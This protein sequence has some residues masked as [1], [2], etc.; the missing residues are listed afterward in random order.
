MN[1]PIDIPQSYI[2]LYGK[3]APRLV[4][5]SSTSSGL[6]GVGDAILIDLTYTQPV[7]VYGAPTLTLN[8]GCNDQS[9][10]IKEIQSFV[11]YADVGMFGIKIGNQSLPNIP[12][13]ISAAELTKRFK[14]IDGINSITIAYR[15]IGDSIYSQG[16]RACAS[17]GNNVTIIFDDVSFPQYQ[18]NI[19]PIFFDTN[20]LLPGPR[21]L[22][23]SG[24][25]SSRL[26][27]KHVTYS[28]SIL[29]NT[30]QDGFNKTDSNATYIYGNG[31][32]V[33]TF[34]YIVEYG[35][36]TSNLD[37]K[38]INYDF[39]YIYDN[40]T[41][42]AISLTVP[43]FG[44]GPR[45]ITKQASSLSFNSKL[46][47][48]SKV[49]QVSYVTSPND[50]GLY[51]EG[52]AIYIYV[53]FD[54]PIKAVNGDDLSL[55]LSTGTFKRFARYMNQLN[56]DSLSFLHIVQTGDTAAK[57][58][59]VASSSLS[60]G[61]AGAIYR[62]S[63]GNISANIT[64]PNPT[65]IGSLSYS[66]SIQVNTA[67]PYVIKSEVSSS[68]SYTAGDIIEFKLSFSYPVIVYGQ[69][70]F[71][72]RN[73]PR[74]L[75]ARIR[76][77]PANPSF[78][79][80]SAKPDSNA[81]IIV[82]LNTNFQLAMGD[83][84]RIYLPTGF[85]I[86]GVDDIK[87]ISDIR[88]LTISGNDSN[89]FSSI[90][91]NDTIVVTRTSSNI[92]QM[93]DSISITISPSS[94]IFTSPNGLISSAASLYYE[95]ISSQ[96]PTKLTVNQI[97]DVVSAIGIRN[98][99]LMISAIHNSTAMILFAFD[100]PETLSIG[101]TISLAFYNFSSETSTASSIY[102]TNSL[103]VFK[104]TWNYSGND[105]YSL[106]IFTVELAEN[107]INQLFQINISD[108][109][110]LQIP[111]G[112][113]TSDSVKLSSIMSQ[114]GVLDAISIPFISKIC[115]IE[116]L[117]LQYL[118]PRPG[119]VSALTV[120][121]DIP[122]YL[123]K[124]DN[125]TIYLPG[126]QSLSQSSI[127]SECSGGDCEYFS[128]S[129][130]DNILQLSVI[131]S[132]VIPSQISVTL[133]S[134]AGI[135]VPYD[136]IFPGDTVI[137]G[138]IAANSCSMYY[139]QYIRQS[140]NGIISLN[141]PSISFI[142][143][144]SRESILGQPVS[145]ILSFSTRFSLYTR[146]TISITLPG[147]YLSST[148][149]SYLDIPSNKSTFNG[150]FFFNEHS[151]SLT[152][153][154][155]EDIANKSTF[156]NDIAIQIPFSVGLICS[157]Q[158]IS[159]NSIRIS[160]KSAT[161]S[162]NN[163]VVAS[164]CYGFCYSDINYST[165]YT[166]E[167]L[168]VQITVSFFKVM[169]TGSTIRL[170]AQSLDRYHYSNIS[171][172]I[173]YPSQERT[174]NVTIIGWNSFSINHILD[175]P[176]PL[177]INATR[178]FTMSIRGL[179]YCNSSINSDKIRL[180]Y[181]SE[182]E[183]LVTWIELELPSYIYNRL[184]FETSEMVLPSNS[185]VDNSSCIS[186]YFVSASYIPKDY[187]LILSLPN[188]NQY[189]N[190]ST[191]SPAFNESMISWDGEEHLLT[192]SFLFGIIPQDEIQMTVC[193]LR[194]DSL[195]GL[196]RDSN[197]L[198]YSIS[199]NSSHIAA[200]SPFSYVNPVYAITG[201]LIDISVDSDSFNLSSL[202]VSFHINYPLVVGD[203]IQLQISF[204]SIGSNVSLSSSFSSMGS[205]NKTQFILSISAE[206]NAASGWQY[207]NIF[208]TLMT[209]SEGLTGS[210][211]STISWTRSSDYLASATVSVPCVGICLIKI[212]PNLKKSGYIM[213]YDLSIRFDSIYPQVGDEI[214]IPLRYFT[215]NSSISTISSNNVTI[216][217]EGLSSEA[218]TRL[219]FVYID[220]QSLS[221]ISF[222]IPSS[223]GLK[224]PSNGIR[225]SSLL[226]NVSWTSIQRS[227]SLSYAAL[228]IQS[229]GK[230]HYLHLN[231]S[232]T[233]PGV[234]ANVTVIMSLLD[235][236]HEG[237]IFELY[238]PGFV[239]SQTTT[240]FDRTRATMTV[241]P[242]YREELANVDGS[243]YFIDHI[244]RTQFLILENI[245]ADSLIKFDVCNDVITPL[246][247]VYGSS[248]PRIAL[249]SSYS[250]IN[251]ITIA[252]TTNIGSLYPISLSYSVS[253]ESS[254]QS[255]YLNA[256]KVSAVNISFMINC[257]LILNDSIIFPLPDLNMNDGLIKDYSIL[258]SRNTSSFT[259]LWIKS[260]TS[261]TMR[262]VSSSV[263]L[264][265]GNIQL[266]IYPSNT[267]LRPKIRYLNAT[268]YQYLIQSSLCPVSDAI[269]D[270]SSTSLIPYSSVS[271]SCDA[272]N[273]S[274]SIT[275]TFSCA[276][277]LTKND[278]IVINLPQ[279]QLNQ[280]SSIIS[281]LSDPF[282][283]GVITSLSTGLQISL[284]LASSVSAL[285]QISVTIPEEF[286][287]TS[288]MYG[289]SYEDVFLLSI[290]SN[291]SLLLS[292]EVN[293]PKNIGYFLSSSIDISSGTAG[294]TGDITF[295]FRLSCSLSLGDKVV[296]YLP[297]FST[298]DGA[299][300]I[301]K[302]TVNIIASWD[303]A[304]SE[305]SFTMAES[306]SKDS[307]IS[308]QISSALIFPSD[309]ISSDSTIFK[310]STVSSKCPVTTSN[311]N[312]VSILPKM[313][314][315][316]S[317]IS[318]DYPDVYR[319]GGNKRLIVLQPGHELTNMDIG[320]LISIQ[321]HIYT[322]ENIE[323]NLLYIAEN[324]MG[325]DIFLGQPYTLIR[326]SP[327]RPAVY[328]SGSGTNELYFN[329][330]VRRGD[331]THQLRLQ[332]VSTD[333]YTANMIDL[334]DGKIYRKSQSPSLAA[335]LAINELIDE[336][337]SDINTDIPYI[338]RIYSTSGDYFYSEGDCIDI[339]VEFSHPVI[340]KYHSNG[341]EPYL[342]LA[343]N[344]QGI[345]KA[346]YSSGLLTN[347]LVFV[348]T[349][350]DIDNQIGISSNFI[351]SVTMM[352]SS[353]F[354]PFRVIMNNK[355][356][357]LRRLSNYPTLDA[358]VQISRNISESFNFNGSIDGQAP[359]VSRIYLP[360]RHKTYTSGDWLVIYVE[361]TS[362][363]SINTDLGSPYIMIE[364]GQTDPQTAKYI[365]QIDNQ[366]I[367]FGYRFSIDDSID[368]GLYLH[369]TCQDYF[370]RTMI[371]LN[372]SIIYSS[373]NSAIQASIILAKDSNDSSLAI[374][375]AF[376]L[377]NSSP[378]IFS[379]STNISNY[380]V[381]DVHSVGSIIDISVTFSYSIR[382]QGLVWMNLK[383]S[384]GPCFAF[385]WYGNNT[386]VLHFLYRATIDS[387]VAKLDYLTTD[388]IFIHSG[389]IRRLSDYPIVDAN[390]TLFPLGNVLSLG[391]S[392]G[393]NIN[394][395][396][397]SIIS[398]EILS[399][400][401]PYPIV[402]TLSELS[403]VYNMTN[404]SIVLAT[405]DYPL[406][407]Y[408]I[409]DTIISSIEN[410]FIDDISVVIQ[411]SYG[412]DSRSILHIQQSY[413][414]PFQSIPMMEIE[415]TL[416]SYMTPIQS[417]WWTRYD[418]RSS[419]DFVINFDRN[420]TG[421]G[422]YL[423]TSMES[424]LNRA[425][426]TDLARLEY[427]LVA[428]IQSSVYSD[429]KYHQFQFSYGGMLSNCLTVTASST[430]LDSIAAGINSIPSLKILSP[431]VS[432]M[433]STSRYHI[434]NIQFK[435]PLSYDLSVYDG[436]GTC[437][438]PI[439]PNQVIFLSDES[440][441]FR[442]HIRSTDSIIL[443]V[444]N[445]IPEGIYRVYLS[446]S[447]AIGVTRRGIERN[448]IKLELIDSNG[449]ISSS[450]IITSNGT[451]GILYSS[452]R[453]DSQFPGSVS[454]VSLLVCLNRGWT[455]GDRLVVSMTGFS[456]PTDFSYQ[457][458]YSEI[459][460]NAAESQ[461]LL[462]VS[463]NLSY[464]ISE[465]IPTMYG[466]TL[467][468]FALYNAN[469]GNI[470]Y[471]LNT[472][473]GNLIN[474]SFDNISYTGLEDV[475]LSFANPRPDQA[476]N[477]S[478]YIVLL[479]PL[480]MNSS[481]SI[482]LPGFSRYP[483]SY[484]Y[485]Y[486]NLSGPSSHHFSSYWDDVNQR[487]VLQSKRRLQAGS[488]D[489][490][491]F[492]TADSGIRI[493]SYGLS[494]SDPPNIAID[495]SNVTISDTIIEDYPRILGSIVSRLN[496]SYNQSNTREIVSMEYTMSFGRELQ[497]S[498]W[499]TLTL[500]FIS[501]YYDSSM[502]SWN[503]SSSMRYTWWGWNHSFVIHSSDGLLDEEYT[504][505]LSDVPQ[506]FYVNGL[507]IP[508][509]S[510]G[511]GS[512]E[513]INIK[514]DS[515]A[516]TSIGVINPIGVI[517]SSSISFS[518]VNSDVFSISA[519][520][521]QVQLNSYLISDDMINI[522]IRGL[523][524]DN[525]IVINDSCISV[526]SNGSIVDDYLISLKH[527][528][529]SA[530]QSDLAL[531]IWTIPI[532]SRCYGPY[533]I[534]QYNSKAFR[535]EWV[536]SEFSTGVVT[537]SEFQTIGILSSSILFDERNPGWQSNMTVKLV[538]S[539]LLKPFDKLVLS[540]GNLTLP[541]NSSDCLDHYGY[542]WTATFSTKANNYT[543]G[544]TLTLETSSAV[545][546][547]AL[548]FTFTGDKAPY[549]PPMGIS[550]EDISSY[551]ISIARDSKMLF[552][553]KIEHVDQVGAI[554]YIFLRAVASEYSITDKL[555]RR[556]SWKLILLLNDKLNVGDEIRI[557]APN[558]DFNYDSELLVLYDNDAY[559][560]ST[561][562][563]ERYISIYLLQQMNTSSLSIDIL[564][565]PAITVN[566]FKCSGNNSECYVNISIRSMAAPITSYYYIPE[567][568]DFLQYSS[569][570]LEVL[571]SLP[572][573][574]PT[575]YP[576]SQPSSQPSRM[577]SCQP[578][579]SPSCYPSSR[580]SSQPRARPSS[581]PTSQ[582][583]SLP[584]SQP[585]SMPSSRPSAQ[586]H[587]QPTLLPTTSPTSKPSSQPILRPSSPPTSQPSSLPTSVPSSAP[588]TRPITQPSSQ[589]TRQPSSIPTSYPTM[590]P[591]GLPTSQPSS[592]P[593]SIPSCRPSQCPTGTPSA[594][595]TSIPSA[596]PTAI[597]TSH[598]TSRPSSQPTRQPSCQP[599]QLPCVSQQP[600]APTGRR[601]VNL[602]DI[603]ETP[604]SIST[605]IPSSQPTSQPSRRPS[606]QPSRQPFPSPTST[607]SSCP[608]VSP[609]NFP[610]PYYLNIKLAFHLS[611]VF[612]LGSSLRIHIPQ[613][614]SNA[615][616]DLVVLDTS[617]IDDS[618][619]DPEWIG[620][621]QTL[622][623]TAT[624]VFYPGYQSFTIGSQQLLLNS[625][626]IY[627][628]DS[629][630]TYSI[631][632]DTN[633][634]T[635]AAGN[636]NFVSG[637]GLKS[638]SLT[639]STPNGNTISRLHIS[640]ES[641]KY[642][643]PNDRIYINLPGF[644]GKHN[645]IL[646]II[647]LG[648]DSLSGRW[649]NIKATIYL[650]VSK[651][652][653]LVSIDISESN[654][655]F[656]GRNGS[657]SIS[658]YPTISLR[659]RN[660]EY[661]QPTQFQHFTP[662]GIIYQSRLS[663]SSYAMAGQSSE[664]YISFQYD[665]G[666]GIEIFDAFYLFLPRFWSDSIDRFIPNYNVSIG[667]FELE[668]YASNSTIIMISQS[669]LLGSSLSLQV[670]ISGFRIPV[671]GLDQTLASHINI[672]TNAT[673]GIVSSRA[674]DSI[675]LIPVIYTSKLVISP[676]IVSQ[677]TSLVIAIELSCNL[678]QNDTLSIYIPGIS[679]NNL[680]I[681]YLLT[682]YS[683]NI[684]TSHYFNVSW[685][686]ASHT[687][688]LISMNTVKARTLI[689]IIA[690][691][692]IE[693]SSTG[694]PIEI[695]QTQLIPTLSLDS[696][697][698]QLVSV[699][700]ETVS[701]IG[702]FNSHVYYELGE[703]NDILQ[704]RVQFELSQGSLAIGD[705]IR[706]VT[707]F[708]SCSN[709]NVSSMGDTADT[710]FS[711][712]FNF[713]WDQSTSSF[714]LI[715]KSTI[716][717]RLL[718]VYIGK[719]NP[720]RVNL[721]ANDT[722]HTI[723]GYIQAIGE[724]DPKEIA[725][726]PKDIGIIRPYSSVTLSSCEVE[727][728]AV[729]CDLD[730][731]IHV[732]RSLYSGDKIVLS[733]GGFYRNQDDKELSIDGN[734]SE[735]VTSTYR[736]RDN[737][738]IA[739]SSSNIRLL[740]ESSYLN[741]YSDIS[742]QSVNRSI[743]WELANTNIGLIVTSVPYIE[744]IYAISE[745]STLFCGDY[746]AIHIIF[747]EPVMI[748]DSYPKI[749][750][751]T[752]E[753]ARYHHGNMTNDI[754]FIYYIS[755]DAVSVSDLSI[756]SP[757]AIYVS[758]SNG[759]VSSKDSRIYA[760]ITIPAP[761]DS[762]LR[763]EGS[764]SSLAV[765]CH[766]K[767]SITAIEI[768]NTLSRDVLYLSDVVDIAVVY[769][770]YVQVQGS[771]YLTL[772]NM[773]VS[774][775]PM[776]A[777]FVNVSTIQ[778]I[779]IDDTS[780]QLAI[781]YDSISSSCFDPDNIEGICEALTSL[782]TLPSSLPVTITSYGSYSGY[783]Y[784]L[785]FKGPVS[786]FKIDIS[787]SLCGGLNSGKVY[788]DKSYL[789]RVIF[790]YT[791]EPGNYASSLRYIDKDSLITDDLN[792]VYIPGHE[793]P[794]LVNNSISEDLGR[795]IYYQGNNLRIKSTTAVV[796]NVYANSTSKFYD[797][798][799]IVTIVVNF[800]APIIV[801]GT[802][803]LDLNI[804]SRI[805]SSTSIVRSEESQVSLSEA[806]DSY[807]VFQY[808]VQSND[809]ASPLDYKSQSS[810]IVSNGSI[811]L[812]SLS[813]SVS[814][815]IALPNPGT[816]ASLSSSMVYIDA[817][818]H[819]TL[820]NITVT[821]GSGRY[822]QSQTIKFE[823][824]F[825][826]IVF[827][828]HS[829][830]GVIPV[831]SWD[832][833]DISM[834][835]DSGSGS[836]T[837]L[838]SYT[839]DLK[840]EET[841][842]LDQLE[843]VSLSLSHGF[844][845][846][847]LGNQWTNMTYRF[848]NTTLRDIV[849]SNSPVTVLYLNSTSLDGVCYPGQVLDI[850]IVFSKD[851]AVIGEP[852]IEVFVYDQY[853]LNQLAKYKSGN[854]SNTLHF[855]YVIPIAD[856]RFNYH[857]YL[858]FDYGGVLALYIYL[859][860]TNGS[861][862]YEYSSILSEIIWNSTINL[863]LPP[864]DES[865]VYFN[866]EIYVNFT[867]IYIVSV[868][869]VSS[870]GTYTAGDDIII[871]IKFSQRVMMFVNPL[872][873]LNTGGNQN[874]S[875]I[876]IGGNHTDRFLFRYR[877]A[878]GDNA[879]RLD[880]VDTRY[881]PYSFSNYPASL[882]LNSRIVE[883]DMA[884]KI[885]YYPGYYG[886][887][888]TAST[889]NTLTPI[890]Y[891]L[892][893]PGAPGSLSYESSI[894]IDTNKPVVK[895]VS[896]VGPLIASIGVISGNATIMIRVLFNA[897]V[898]VG[899][900]P[901]ISF[902]LSD[903]IRYASYYNG[904]GSDS[905]Y[906]TLKLLKTD[907]V[908]SLD[909]IDE[910]SLQLYPCNKSQSYLAKTVQYDV[911][912]IKRSSMN[913][914]IHANIT[915]PKV[916]YRETIISPTSITGAGQYVTISSKSYI[917]SISYSD[918]ML[919]K[920]GPGDQISVYIEFYG[921]VMVPQNMS[922][923]LRNGIECS[924]DYWSSGYFK[925]T[926][927][928]IY[929]VQSQDY[930][931]SLTYAG[932]NAVTVA[933]VC[934]I[935]TSSGYCASYNLPEPSDVSAIDKMTINH[936]VISDIR[937]TITSITLQGLDVYVGMDSISGNAF[938]VPLAI[939]TVAA[940]VLPYYGYE[941]TIIESYMDKAASIT[942]HCNKLGY[943]WF[944]KELLDAVNGVRVIYRTS[945]PN[946]VYGNGSNAY[947]A[948]ENQDVIE[949]PLSP[950][951][952]SL[953]SILNNV[954]GYA[955]NG[956]AIGANV[957][958]LSTS[959][960]ID[961]C[962]G[963]VNVYGEYIYAVLPLCLTEQL[964]DS[965]RDHSPQIGWALDG[966]PIY[967]PYGYNGTIMLPCSSTLSDPSYCLDDCNGFEGYLS[968]I[969]GYGYRYYL[970]RPPTF[971]AC[972]ESI[973]DCNIADAHPC[974]SLTDDSS[975]SI[976]TSY[977]LTCLRG[978]A[979]ND[980]EACS[981]VSDIVIGIKDVPIITPS[982]PMA[983]Y[984]YSILSTNRALSSYNSDLMEYKPS[985]VWD[986]VILRN[987]TV[988]YPGD[989]ILVKV[990]LSEA[991]RVEGLPYIVLD[992]NGEDLILSYSHQPS[993]TEIIFSTIVSEALGS[994]YV[995]CSRQSMIRFTGGRILRE[996]NFLPLISADMNIGS[997]CCMET[998]D[999]VGYVE[1000]DIPYVID[1001][1002][1003][1004]PENA[1005]YSAGD[1006][1007]DIY[1008]IFS[1009][1010]VVVIGTLSLLLD[1011]QDD[1012]Y[1013]LFMYHVN[1014]TCLLFR[1015]IVSEHDG[1016]AALDYPSHESLV[1017][1018]SS[1019]S[1020]DG[1021]LAYGS[1022]SRIKANLSLPSKGSGRSLGRSSIRIDQ[1023]QARIVGIS[1024]YPAIATIGDTVM[1025]TIT[1026]DQRISLSIPVKDIS[1027]CVSLAMKFITV[1028][1029]CSIEDSNV[1030]SVSGDSVTFSYRVTKEN[1031]DSTVYLHPV[1032]P[1033]NIVNGCNFISTSS[1034]TIASL[1035]I[1036]KMLQYQS[1037]FAIDVSVPYVSSVYIPSIKSS[1038][1039][1040]IGDIIYIH[1041]VFSLDVVV[1042]L[1043]PSL[1044][1045]NLNGEIAYAAYDATYESNGTNILVFKYTVAVDQY[1046]NPLEYDGIAALTGDIRRAA[1047]SPTIIANTTLP[1048]PSA[1049]G[1050]LSYC[1051]RAKIDSS[1052][1053]FV[1054]YLVPLKES[1055]V[1056]GANEE[1057]VILVRF[1058]KPVNVSGSPYLELKTG[1059]DRVS[1060]ATYISSY[1061]AYDLP[1062]DIED[1063]DVLFLY[1064]VDIE[1065]NIVSLHHSGKYAIML[1066][1067]SSSNSSEIAASITSNGY[1068]ANTLLREPTDFNPIDGFVY[1069]QWRHRYPSKVELLIRDLYHSQPEYLSI[1070]LQHL[1071]GSGS[1072]LNP[1073]TAS[1074]K[1075]FGQTYA[1076]SNQETQLAST[1077]K[1078]S[1079]LLKNNVLIDKDIDIGNSY[1080]FSDAIMK[1081]IAVDGIATQSSTLSYSAANA[1082]DGDIRS[1083]IHFGS[1084]SQTY[1085]LNQSWWKL[1086]L[1087]L[1088]TKSIQSIVIYPRKTET[1089]I[1090]WSLLLIIKGL[1091]RY[1092]E[1093]SF[1094]LQFTNYDA[1095]NSSAMIITNPIS[1096]SASSDDLKREIEIFIELGAVAVNRTILPTCGVTSTTGCG[1097]GIEH[1098]Y[1099]Y[1100]HSI[1101]FL[1102][1103]TTTDL[1104]MSIYNTSF[1105]GGYVVNDAIGESSNFLSSYLVT[1106]IDIIRRGYYQLSDPTSYPGSSMNISNEW[1107]S[1108]FWVMLFADDPSKDLN[1109]SISAS[1110]WS[1111][1112]YTSIDNIL[1113]I[1114]LPRSYSVSY[1115]KIQ[1116]EDVGSLS[1117]AEVEVYPDRINS[1118]SSYTGDS[1119]L[1120]STPLTSPLQPEDSFDRAFN[1121]LFYDGRWV[1122]QIQQFKPSEI[1123]TSKS[1124][1125][1126]L[1127]NYLKPSQFDGYGTVSDV[1128]LVVTDMAGLVKAYH[1129]DLQAE[1130]TSL[1131]KYGTLSQTSP[1132]TPH[1133]YG[1134][1135]REEFELGINGEL[1136]PK[1137]SGQRPLDACYLAQSNAMK[1138]VLA[1139]DSD[1140]NSFLACT[1141]R[1142]LYRYLGDKPMDS[1143]Q[1144]YVITRDRFIRYHPD[1145]SFLGPDFFTYSIYDG[1146]A[1147]QS[1148]IK[1149]GPARP[1150][1151]YSDGYVRS[1152]E[1153]E[1154]TVHTRICGKY[1155][1156]QL[1157]QYS[1158]GMVRSKHAMCSCAATESATIGT[1159]AACAA[1160]IET[1161]CDE[1162][1163]GSGLK[1164]NFRFLCDA[1165]EYI[1166]D[1167]SDSSLNTNVCLANK[1168]G[1169]I[1170][1171]GIS[1172]AGFVLDISNRKCLGQINRAVSFLTTRG[1173]CSA[1174][1175]V[1176]DCSNEIITMTG[1177][1178]A[1179]NYLS[1180]RA[1181]VGDLSMSVTGDSIGGY[1182]WFD[1183]SALN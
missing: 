1101:T 890:N 928:F 353:L 848:D 1176:M 1160:A 827:I 977:T 210:S 390:T 328:S 485:S 477:M 1127:W 867:S 597:P 1171:N 213:S 628:N 247:G 113:V 571:D 1100:S 797:T 425:F 558:Y 377:D 756:D 26:K 755:S 495:S 342:Q 1096:F 723:S 1025:I 42:E 1011:L 114:N 1170:S 411:S 589:P 59:Y 623:L 359:R 534:V 364:T 749:L 728:D 266:L 793:V 517:K 1111:K 109:V 656:I 286:G 36:Q 242:S 164:V 167:E 152:I 985:T 669:R 605:I 580:P 1062:I 407:E 720:M 658:G 904:S 175:I 852:C 57:L 951:L 1154:V 509:Q 646:N 268:E 516:A 158:S 869:S 240:L 156:M 90:W 202:N 1107:L 816:S 567:C 813:Q 934:D 179:K 699:T 942:N 617:S 111:S 527:S 1159:L 302:A 619:W 206:Y 598:P 736:P 577:P 1065:D 566:F 1105:A 600:V 500:P 39:G 79:F 701:Y 694:F 169:M 838:F 289:I 1083:G 46:S 808:I 382:V 192:L 1076:L 821:S 659:T 177:S 1102:T 672:S 12:A 426:S 501:S 205:W 316:I 273:S 354:Q 746:V 1156:R 939:P 440:I 1084:V 815:I 395:Y 909:Y 1:L 674:L 332:N 660:W 809:L 480:E 119:A 1069:G 318:S 648:N 684:S 901:R 788:Y 1141:N 973:Q 417:Y 877:V 986:I 711:P 110:S 622:V 383:G 1079:S 828:D 526:S 919:R 351:S 940:D 981:A 298:D 625:Y 984:N 221:E 449:I 253:R 743:P 837:L 1137:P 590:Q 292:Y 761:Y 291:D 872:L 1051:S 249:L 1031:S 583:S 1053:P 108:I 37:V 9:C 320:S 769:D 1182:G 784:K 983:V 1172:S 1034:G 884:R 980:Y 574:S 611:T 295:T 443:H 774:S 490:T 543:I 667:S 689:Q 738:D 545:H 729:G 1040:H 823:Y 330:L 762:L 461:L 651:I 715:A 1140:A 1103:L 787:S 1157:E 925:D 987:N 244:A 402:M 487:V 994:G 150:T 331:S 274:T 222:T 217:L 860:Q 1091:D 143:T 854:M 1174:K 238:L 1179:V 833:A 151:Q 418:I 355:E 630:L 1012:S 327:V 1048:W 467:P 618:Y 990:T 502:V 16:D 1120:S 293:H 422:L 856:E 335:L 740:D 592:Q 888:F 118:N 195:E 248:T 483:S 780:G 791:V 1021:V 419:F 311:V 148:D 862:L 496:I 1035:T 1022:F 895:T 514:G 829:Q 992:F 974:C 462:I 1110:V 1030:K 303:A 730:V 132:D 138:I 72:I 760:N 868:S 413:F 515:L 538:T 584:S 1117:L 189:S 999:V 1119:I 696:K 370:N 626:I 423:E 607:P 194:Y 601:L 524:C 799:D 620:S 1168:T 896:I 95:L 1078:L 198:G 1139:Y 116:D 157:N 1181:P 212:N 958:Y 863:H 347:T 811:I 786:P 229:I 704:I 893:I 1036:P 1075:S 717:A 664:L 32:C 569:I 988:Y 259:L 1142:D 389:W 499:I 637:R 967:G 447:N 568:V 845:Y 835:Y 1167:E 381:S 145:A 588:T 358:N 1123:D 277:P 814:A 757:Y 60:L 186:F 1015:Y 290:Y 836:N 523:V 528:N 902:Y 18:G 1059:V 822:T 280:S 182:S 208:N 45:Y 183:S 349:V 281:S 232:E 878:V 299:L 258:S 579:G 638:S 649:N 428:T 773:N 603:T 112:G 529:E 945:C 751:N 697:E 1039:Y 165:I 1114:M 521:I 29:N 805:S 241:F 575:S 796:A 737:E 448:R 438:Y 63:N 105:S 338:T 492:T 1158:Q 661:Y 488:Y 1163:D 657:D 78:S 101:D 357:Y 313:Y 124:G 732:K 997:A 431:L 807:L 1023:S 612:Q 1108:P 1087:P 227:K 636:F 163:A 644:T 207:I 463:E 322:I 85:H 460:F 396:P 698:G 1032:S 218:S 93:N 1164:Q 677:S 865:Y 1112:R 421:K 1086:Q 539:T 712:L 871:A 1077:H 1007:I 917:E 613:I 1092:P 162:L 343:I 469:Q 839:I 933:A 635:I 1038:A 551:S 340:S 725:Y 193:G 714:L 439:D 465:A 86:R 1162:E 882:A 881:S 846:D 420:V 137:A 80:P 937:P 470:S 84:L 759:I 709:V 199:V 841:L 849:L 456:C 410:I 306:V 297:G 721:T 555:S 435:R 758:D 1005:V 591:I 936:L 750:L 92:A 642:F 582:P 1006:R 159:Y 309:G 532:S 255:Q 650:T 778:W 666:V 889:A 586:P 963:F 1106:R 50:D 702:L 830:D 946:H 339:H 458:N 380:L 1056:Y 616:Y 282:H 1073:G 20:N 170:I 929:A 301:S 1085:A 479:V 267:F 505:F 688:E 629:S 531:L 1050:S 1067:N 62:Y 58:D 154:L 155:E 103:D 478:A 171:G 633:N 64:L 7:N 609:S 1166:G 779:D 256:I 670:N 430:G 727:N 481:I 348:Y 128:T 54:L 510:D 376:I 367:S 795:N 857:P 452:I 631:F 519:I 621:N 361:Y 587:S 1057:I 899:G 1081:N 388:S 1026:Y 21:T 927:G 14:E 825:N 1080:L 437:S 450:S 745:L 451:P 466:L 855:E 887:I 739:I 511:Q 965:L 160:I 251:P 913:P 497:G 375:E 468:L 706:I 34:Q 768:A 168:M 498:T 1116:R 444:N 1121:D 285:T 1070:K 254:N 190:L 94:G 826:G 610:T 100:L 457:G 772:W 1046:A 803:Y 536:S 223:F 204:L 792:Y 832:V 393:I 1132:S 995:F 454:T 233:N 368:Q 1000:T 35:D 211:R 107:T 1122:V 957:D 640:F 387:G 550:T 991:V 236:L 284:P 191:I 235:D 692:S 935:I 1033:I 27:G 897:S 1126:D 142:T 993:S 719:E 231:I 424:P 561:H 766:S 8:T 892:P 257:P 296:Y 844:F 373:N 847:I 1047:D 941:D 252:N 344:P 708:V 859:S 230:F 1169:S 522:Y 1020:Y 82:N 735:Y 685:Y 540:I 1014:S 237:D 764:F 703:D 147:F 1095:I 87:N 819:P 915:L 1165:C 122:H 1133:P 464:C 245:P 260:N 1002:Y 308:I 923:S 1018:S 453:F 955:L 324:Y 662:V 604:T 1144:Q 671:G 606:S 765:S 834:R 1175:P 397:P 312:Q 276:I 1149:A 950:L 682:N 1058:N 953:S 117:A 864:A 472:S 200:I 713:S 1134:D 798:G 548:L 858:R 399:S 594:R 883:K 412:M 1017:I 310:V 998:C 686:D 1131:P 634:C 1104:N 770:R 261:L 146:D 734:I 321:D 275:L 907:S 681:P 776:I 731:F 475:R 121:W 554:S 23:P 964:K 1071:S 599:S 1028:I 898:V 304:S 15:D 1055:G 1124:D 433:E 414:N 133:S 645:Q 1138:N 427:K 1115:I 908:T 976:W 2:S 996:A 140:S 126:N 1072:I 710:G 409:S 910:N 11:C 781:Y 1089:W 374:D 894:S 724:L 270:D 1098:G 187:L 445:T 294:S 573:L 307:L 873:V 196:T 668:Y 716:P 624:K 553:E 1173:L 166:D 106:G 513:V 279:F 75:N 385:F 912:Y 782:S 181:L 1001:V 125:I 471:Y 484:Y 1060:Y 850:H 593:T 96:V 441:A 647:G 530:C 1013:G 404:Q 174:D 1135:W 1118:L 305:L 518:S 970:P 880:Y 1037:I 49:P 1063:T 608:S 1068:A 10:I 1064:N 926:W 6:F 562:A 300:S 1042:I 512:I 33:L 1024:A 900:C 581:N 564:P 65:E 250:P 546:P 921:S 673:N 104:T 861:E 508:R 676:A 1129:Q 28:P 1136:L 1125:E 180:E 678:H 506:Q 88:N 149:S 271:Y 5:I 614:N 817:S 319:Y 866:R 442:Y 1074:F 216:L 287:I 722:T 932:V 801:S 1090:P 1052:L 944:Y 1003:S 69:P 141:N 1145:E 918:L 265:S 345:V 802:I 178:Y 482:Y 363:M 840:S 246:K 226:S 24:I 790:R 952:P 476:S 48:F 4:S 960:Y 127:T 962:G 455:I 563:S 525:A 1178:N 679:W 665:S 209:L 1054:K 228:F 172:S 263:P 144:D 243:K 1088:S 691:D 544:N 334:N 74:Y 362:A 201:A 853:P 775:S 556:V 982:I 19:P 943:S 754:S 56:N 384:N 1113:N 1152:D 372:H 874:N 641:V 129:I 810:L 394:T 931:P 753:Y 800:S 323:E 120:S 406:L 576:T 1049:V 747:N 43:Y 906:F 744:Y 675:Q 652:I 317:F 851:I 507:G 1128:V 68:R 52:D 1066:S 1097:Y 938:G 547:R 184:I 972:S 346:F 31:T 429:Y 366:T 565:S 264:L 959:R 134:S 30:I 1044:R 161:S 337:I 136:G 680:E 25:A 269:I 89:S 969:D 283:D 474:I 1029:D 560:V 767:A 842:D 726:S 718:N 824:M 1147:K 1099:G 978:C 831:L 549:L 391:V 494:E 185:S 504:L 1130:I 632:D 22:Q 777:S 326:S 102:T 820:S 911:L 947:C 806:F 436:K 886:G 1148:H 949:I 572:S 188:F 262:L 378:I 1151:T 683:G 83:I 876:F 1153:N 55:Q 61:S 41:L 1109:A 336:D 695:N 400:L 748:Q 1146:V 473:D 131:S 653:S 1161:V 225:Y 643:Y 408:I 578:S 44:S 219:R 922:L 130:V 371:Q 333:Q 288:S 1043:T 771:P 76:A 81:Q 215:V 1045:L 794:P 1093:G 520:T 533:A 789:N 537:F 1082:I 968:E 278:S 905:L 1008:I 416:G 360:Y 486:L 655:L 40:T 403:L 432:L 552:S 77:A 3:Y 491:V 627:E 1183:T 585:V 654:M 176:M 47:I 1180:L 71:W 115:G 559:K 70:Y 153:V 1019:G 920:Y 700:F 314:A 1010:P 91:L 1009:R 693:V 203:V 234:E 350:T 51:T 415:E 879:K 783:R 690:N 557:N 356:D 763:T 924:L 97:F 1177:R 446:K 542:K 1094:R 98:V 595:P 73:F 329:Y 66:K 903:S 742:Y 663:F 239:I 173:S 503:A 596:H 804:S 1027:N 392:D 687:L 1143:P 365:Q 705:Y 197:Q 325:D 272:V 1150:L 1004:D 916:N 489:I 214:V 13:N 99:S 885:S 1155:A 341:S 493:S 398:W 17:N 459:S 135:I 615:S 961:D 570:Q 966:Y 948:N 1061:D 535:L 352:N 67:A 707:P 914:M 220:N 1041:V 741:A 954:S 979:M 224:T 405:D 989:W 971:D 870:N 401:N 785:E 1016:T 541:W 812:D 139:P 315:S 602:L 123:S 369:C 53:V 379:I 930:S 434:Y 975:L 843:T 891:D 875:A 639:V 733:S 752:N 956:V 818:S 386:K 38:S